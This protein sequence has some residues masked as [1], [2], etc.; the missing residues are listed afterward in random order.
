MFVNI[1]TVICKR[2]TFD[3]CNANKTT[4]R[5]KSKTVCKARIHTSV[6][7]YNVIKKKS[8]N[9]FVTRKLGKKFEADIAVA[10]WEKN[11]PRKQ[12]RTCRSDH[13]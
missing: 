10:V 9:L 1:I 11:K 5:L 6:G 4:V 12:W 3:D 2:Y 13:N 7:D 8:R